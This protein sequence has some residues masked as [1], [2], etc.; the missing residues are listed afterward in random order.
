MAQELVQRLGYSVRQACAFLELA[1]SSYYYA[2]HPRQDPK[3]EDNLQE[4]AGKYPRYGTR[5]LT[6]ELRRKTYGYQVNRKRIQRL[7]R[8]KGLLRPVK[9]RKTRTT[10]SQHPYPRYENRGKDLP[11]VRPEQVWV[12]DITYIRLGQGFVYLAIILDLFTRAVRG[13]C[14]SLPWTSR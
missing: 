5:R 4:V 11:I 14:L 3:M 10:N 7:A 2:S 9:R 1:P 12:S 8:E 6:H 13:W